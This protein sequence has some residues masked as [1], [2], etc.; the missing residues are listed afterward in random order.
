MAYDLEER[1]ALFAESII[2]LAGQVKKTVVTLP[3]ISQLVRSGT[4]IGAN[5]RE[6]NGASSK[7]DFRNKIYIC[8]KE[9]K[10]TPQAAES[11]PQAVREKL[12]Q[13]EVMQAPVVWLASEASNGFNGQRII[14]YFWDERVPLEERLQ[15]ASA[16]AAWP[17]LG[18]QAIFPGR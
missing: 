3:I 11:L 9:A 10:E 4:S 17:Q 8:K 2:S 16:P 6:A 1:T 7:R 18:R 14:A 13:P 15:R 12:I 5:Y